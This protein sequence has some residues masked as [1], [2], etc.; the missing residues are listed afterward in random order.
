MSLPVSARWFHRDEVD[1]APLDSS[2]LRNLPF[3]RSIGPVP[4]G[5]S[6]VALSSLQAGFQ[7]RE[8]LPQGGGLVA[9]IVQLSAPQS[10]TDT[11]TSLKHVMW[12][13]CERDA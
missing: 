7:Q 2:V 13:Q 8:P 1:G 5:R 12:K 10:N 3:R 11:I 9:R 4:P 6:A